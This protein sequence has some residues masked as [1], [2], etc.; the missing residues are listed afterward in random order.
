M[1]RV[2]TSFFL[3]LLICKIFSFNSYQKMSE[4]DTAIQQWLSD[5]K[6]V[7]MSQSSWGWGGGWGSNYETYITI[8]AETN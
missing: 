2:F 8:I 7:S 6:L 5:K 4:I 3:L 1:K